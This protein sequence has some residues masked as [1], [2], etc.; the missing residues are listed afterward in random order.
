MK[1]NKILGPVLAGVM[2]ASAAHAQV[3]VTI[4][5]ST[6]FRSITLDRAQFLFDNGYTKWGDLTG[7]LPETFQGTMSNAIPSLGGTLVTVRCS[8][9]G[10]AAGMLAVDGS[11]PVPTIDPITGNTNS[12]TVP[13][14]ALSDV[15]PEAATPAINGAD[16]DQAVI[17]VIPFVF[18][19]NNALTGITNI[20]REQAVLAMQDSG[21]NGPLAAMPASF[22]GCNNANSNNPIFMT[23]RDSGS[24]TRI[25][26]QADIGFVGTPRL[27]GT[28]ATNSSLLVLTNGYA[29]N[30]LQRNVIASNPNVIGY[31]GLADAVIISG[32]ATAINYEGVPFS[33][34]NVQSG[35]YPLWGYEHFVNRAGQLSQ[36]Q[37][38]IHDALV[39]AITNPGY[40]T[41]NTTYTANFV[42][43]NNM[44]VYRGA[45]GGTIKSL[46]W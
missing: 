5:G 45:D 10:S 1:L 2:L 13:D 4:T 30:G 39:G 40:Q 23:G 17:G 41:T 34:A 20:T 27:W 16:F 22:L 24:G 37:Q 33:I 38:L 3:N 46:N 26:V 43:Q 32:T 18:I 9:S 8:F 25:T 35:Q 28:S 29:S 11:S 6:A 42:D 15:F 44:Q 12:T 19:R 31:L 14:L 21:S 7:T 36:N